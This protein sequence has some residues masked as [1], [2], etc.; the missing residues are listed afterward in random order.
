M[1]LRVHEG[2]LRVA[3]PFGQFWRLRGLRVM[4]RRDDGWLRCGA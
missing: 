3:L 2:E 1:G 4:R